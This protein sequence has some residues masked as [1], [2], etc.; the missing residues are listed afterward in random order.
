MTGSVANYFIKSNI[1]D[2]T[3][4]RDLIERLRKCRRIND[5]IL[6]FFLKT[7]IFLFEVKVYKKI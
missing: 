3:L 4:D 6:I 7:G 2:P 1:G 5:P